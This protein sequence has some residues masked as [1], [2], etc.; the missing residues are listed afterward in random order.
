[1]HA[2]AVDRIWIACLRTVNKMHRSTLRDLGAYLARAV[3]VSAM[4]RTHTV[5]AEMKYQT[6]YTCSESI[7]I[8]YSRN[9]SNMHASVRQKFR[10]DRAQN[11]H[12]IIIFR[13]LN[14]SVS[15]EIPNGIEVQCT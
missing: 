11:V 9:I 3:R 15:N 12:V 13:M 4:F 14:L 8:F 5:S 1:M 6:H 7:M 2:R 10:A